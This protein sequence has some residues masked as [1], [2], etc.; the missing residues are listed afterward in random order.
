MGPNAFDIGKNTTLEVCHTIF[1]AGRCLPPTFRNSGPPA[2]HFLRHPTWET[3]AR[4][5]CAARFRARAAGTN[6][7]GKFLG[8]ER[9]KITSGQTMTRTRR[10]FN[11]TCP[12]PQAQ[13]IFGPLEF[14]SHPGPPPDHIPSARLLP[15]AAQLFPPA[16]Q[17]FPMMCFGRANISHTSSWPRNCFP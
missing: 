2:T 7:E 9:A 12:E 4:N 6:V 11:L 17:L 8:T 5:S 10:S 1:Q 15:P 14:Q 16:A 3:V 13:V